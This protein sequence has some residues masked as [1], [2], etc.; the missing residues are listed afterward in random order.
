MLGARTEGEILFEQYLTS[1]GLAFEFEKEHADTDHPDS[2]DEA[3][4]E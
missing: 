4:D 1:Q 2:L 3:S